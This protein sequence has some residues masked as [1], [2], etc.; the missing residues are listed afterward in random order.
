MLPSEVLCKATTFDLQVL[1]I[2]KSWERLKQNKAHGVMPE[3][4]EEVLLD[5]L[6]K[7]R[8]NDGNT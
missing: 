8:E 7:V 1:D 3:V 5:V 2:A 4:K 6:K